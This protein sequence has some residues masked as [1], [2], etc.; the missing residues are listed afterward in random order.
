MPV[1]SAHV[2]ASHIGHTGKTTLCFQM[3][4]Y[5]AKKHPQIKVLVMDLAEEGDLT[6]RLLGGVDEAGRKIDAL[7]GGVF[8]LLQDAERKSAGGLTNWWRGTSIDLTQHAIQI[9]EHNPAIP[10][11]LYLISSG[12]WPR[13]DPP[14]TAADRKRV[15]DKIKDTLENSADTWKIFCDTDGDRRPSQFTMIGYCLCDRA[16]VPLHLNKADLDRTETML[17]V[18]QELRTSGDINTQVLFIVWNFV[19]SIKDGEMQHNGTTLPFTPAKV[20]LDILDACNARVA[21]IRK[22]LPGLFVHGDTSDDNFIKTSTTV[23]RQL[24][25]NV[26]KPSEELGL[27]FVRIVNQLAESG[28][29]S[30][31]FKSGSVEYT[32]AESLITSV[33]ASLQ[34]IEQKFEAIILD[35]PANSN[36]G[37]DG[38]NAPVA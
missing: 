2:F 10:P 30:L 34:H 26:L 11:N 6:K 20:N 7:F 32:A 23:L 25:D 1:Q 22:D 24:A 14:M 36:T 21:D 13:E 17:G 37:Y 29:S 35:P 12:A 31:K 15:C 5:Y 38:G 33:D 4:C 18:M 19:K 16:I 28:K 9:S 8:K 27:P 3:A